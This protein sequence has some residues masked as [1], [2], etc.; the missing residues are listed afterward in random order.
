MV[1]DVKRFAG[2]ARWH[3]DVIGYNFLLDSATV[4]GSNMI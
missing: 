3:C 1:V 2:R 4:S